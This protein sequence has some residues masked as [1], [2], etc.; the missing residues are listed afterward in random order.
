MITDPTYDTGPFGTVN[1]GKSGLRASRICLGAMTFGIQ[2]DKAEAH[3]MLDYAFDKGVTFFDTA[4]AYGAGESERILGTW[5]KTKR[6]D[7]IVSTKV[8]YQVGSDPMSVG[9]SR[10][11]IRTEVERSLK[12]MQTDFIDVLYLH[13]PDDA[14]AL[15]E[16]LRAVEDVVRSGKVHC[17]G[18]SN[19]AAW[20]IVQALEIAAR[21]HVTAPVIVQPMYNLIARGIEQE[22]MPCCRH[23]QLAVYPYNPLAAG[24]LTGKHVFEKTDHKT[25]RFKVLPY[26]KDRY[27]HHMMFNAVSDL[28]NIAASSGRSLISL[29]FQW[30]LDRPGVTGI[31]MGASNL[32]QL[33][34]NLASFDKPLDEE[35]ARACDELWERFRGPHPNYNR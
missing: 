3:R 22:L 24:L 26:Y 29:A 16:T 9:L 33:E 15:D 7:V 30:L 25:G 12:R 21:L 11:V 18:V 32:Q 8:R 4:N 27:W 23:Y 13:Q 17:L 31:V 2:A 35:T 19:F 6:H 14:T 28:E 10:R 5:I 20:Q 1:L 34:Q